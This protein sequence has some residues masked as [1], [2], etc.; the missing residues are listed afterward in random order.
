M[1]ILILSQWFDPEP[2]FKGLCFAKK[3]K[4]FGHEVEVLTGFPNYP[5]G[6]VYASHKLQ[7]YF[8]E[9]QA[10]IRIHR[11]YLYPDH[12]TKWIKRVLNYLSFGLTAALLGPFFIRR[13]QVIYAYASPATVGLPAVVLSTLFGCPLVLDVQDLWPDSIRATGMVRSRFVLKWIAIFCGWVYRQADSIVVSSNGIRNCLLERGVPPGKVTVIPNWADEDKMIVAKRE[14]AIGERFGLT[15]KFNVTYAGNLGKAQGLETVLMAAQKIDIPRVQF[16][17]VG[18][19]VEKKSLEQM[20]QQLKI[21]NTL[22]IP[23]QEIEEIGKIFAWSDVLL[24]HLK[25]HPLFETAIPSKTQAYLTMSKPILMAVAGNASELILEARAGLVAEPEDSQDLV[26]RVRELY[27]LTEREREAMGNNGLVFYRKQLSLDVGAARFDSLFRGLRKPSIL[28]R[29]SQRAIDVIVSAFFLALLSPIFLL[30]SFL[31]LRKM[32]RPILFRQRRPGRWG[33]PFWL[34][35]FRTMKSIENSAGAQSTDAS[36]LTLLGE[37]LRKWSLDELPQFWNV[38]KGDMTLVG[39]RPLLMEYV[40]RY[41][42]EQLR[43]QYVKPGITGLAQIRGRNLLS[44]DQ[45][46]R[47]DVW[48][49]DH[50]SLCLNLKILFQTVGFVFSRRGVS[51]PGQATVQEFEGNQ[52]DISKSAKR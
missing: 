16:V 36:R 50:Q 14:P 4:R 9:E 37:T 22:F 41:S 47:Y 19:G 3:L 52:R 10:G 51:A 28:Y 8:T 24:V 43:R 35:K 42:T 15:G 25:R 7:P 46:F 39:P 27:E 1:R 30:L 44:W 18:D 21:R 5:T 48:Y 2:F 38:L 23:Q 17:F 31:I 32:G 6:K 40:S 11:T 26:R 29:C 20:K 13:P 12:G 33:A 49:V 45:K 34:Y